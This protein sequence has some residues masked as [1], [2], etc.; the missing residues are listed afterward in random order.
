FHAQMMSEAIAVAPSP[1]QSASFNAWEN[2]ERKHED[3]VRQKQAITQ[4][5]PGL[6]FMEDESHS[7]H[8][9]AWRKKFWRYR[10]TRSESRLIRK[11]ARIPTPIID[12]DEADH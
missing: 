5:L 10:L 9:A 8:P 7:L 3:P 4:V 6:N 1:E 11:P 12:A 2:R